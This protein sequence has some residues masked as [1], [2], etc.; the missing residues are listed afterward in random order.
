MKNYCIII[1]YTCKE[2]EGTFL[3]SE[4]LIG[5]EQQA[6]FVTAWDDINLHEGEVV[7]ELMDRL[8]KIYK[9]KHKSC[10]HK[11]KEIFIIKRR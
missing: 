2:F 7:D 11:S 4:E 6:D 8:D 10:R 9:F 1:C 3:D 5:N